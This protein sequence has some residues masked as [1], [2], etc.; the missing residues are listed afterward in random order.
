MLNLNKKFQVKVYSADSTTFIETINNNEICSDIAFTSK[1]NS[2]Y[3]QLKIRVNRKFDDFDEGVA[4]KSN[5][6][7]RVLEY[8]TL[9]P[10]PRLIY[11]GIITNYKPYSSS[12]GDSGVDI[13]VLGIVSMLTFSLF[14]IGTNFDVTKTSKDPAVIMQ[15]IIDHFNSVYAGLIFCGGNVD[16]VGS[17][18][19]KTFSRKTWMQANE[20]TLKLVGEDWF[21]KI[22]VPE[23]K[24]DIVG[25]LYFK[26]KPSTATHTFTFGKDLDNV[27]SI[28]SSEEVINSVTLVYDG[29][30]AVASDATSIATYGLR[31]KIYE[32]KSIVELSTA[33]KYVDQVIAQN[34]DLKIKTTLKIN[35]NYNLETIKVGETCK[36]LNIK[37]T[38]KTFTD[39]MQIY[40][41][42]YSPE[43]VTLEL[44]AIE[45]SFGFQLNKF[46]NN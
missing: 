20:E 29:G 3:G 25:E 2:G 42:Q 44:E 43:V 36:I 40:S 10:D 12:D 38:Q 32:D 19:S 13:N 34:K 23:S 7:V 5:N 39:N 26:Q 4:I 14:K 33:Q 16:L 46:V 11:C 35:Q 28:K 24:N 18:V 45:S 22:E 6:I 21:W 31:E 30:T 41:V 27:S 1:I 17:N 37:D 8:D 15:E 9:N